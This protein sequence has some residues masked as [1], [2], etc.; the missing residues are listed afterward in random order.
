MTAPSQRDEDEGFGESMLQARES[1]S[2][3]TKFVTWEYS[4]IY[5][6]SLDFD[7]YIR[8]I[9]EYCTP[10]WSPSRQYLIDELENVQRRFTA[11]ILARSGLF[12]VPYRRRLTL[13]NAST[14]ALRRTI[15][16]LNLL[17]NSFAGNIDSNYRKIFTLS[18]FNNFTR[19]HPFRLSSERVRTQKFR[20]SF[21]IRVVRL[22]NELPGEVIRSSSSSAFNR[23]IERFLRE[24]GYY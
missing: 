18:N 8:P 4:T 13:L 17:Y 10:L 6:D 1:S 23:A 21:I 11:R 24:K 19:G 16:D 20:E 5:T 14:L 15:Y 9:L 22:W 7:E 2:Y 3:L 12:H